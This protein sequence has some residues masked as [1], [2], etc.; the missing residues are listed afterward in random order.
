MRFSECWF[1]LIL[2]RLI[3]DDKYYTI[4][5]NLTDANVGTRKQK[6]TNDNLFVVNA[7]FNSI[8]RGSEEPI[9]LC[10][11]DVKKCFDALWRY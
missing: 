11:Y 5:E 1:R 2:K 6:N 9:D 4:D 10:I 7:K 3:Y 8:K